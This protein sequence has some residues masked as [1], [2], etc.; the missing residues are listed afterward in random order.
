MQLAPTISNT[1]DRFGHDIVT[2]IKSTMEARGAVATGAT[3]DSLRYE[4]G[5]DYVEIIGDKAFVWIEKGR[6]PTKQGSGT[7][8]EET[9][10]EKLVRWIKAKGIET[11]EKEVTRMSWALA[12]KIHR[13]GTAL[14]RA[15]A[16]R[17]V[18][19]DII[20]KQRLQ[21]LKKDLGAAVI[22]SVKSELLTAFK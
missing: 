18:Y 14:H 12:T 21:R 5:A 16:T 13:E 20:T 7:T 2:E 17:F 10:R 6:G 19:S 1:L 22:A 3:R 15:G 11:D 9:L 4:A 8:G